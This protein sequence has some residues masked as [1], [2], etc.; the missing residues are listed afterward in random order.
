[1]IKPFYLDLTEQE[2]DKIKSK[3]GEILKSGNLILS[4]YTEDF[5]HEFAKYIGCKYAV[6]LNSCTSA[7]EA[8]LMVKDAKNKKVAV[9]TNTN[10]ATVAAIIRA[11]G[12]PIYMDMTPEYFV[13]DMNILKYTLKKHSDISGVVWVH[14][15]GIIAPDFEEIAEFCKSKNIFL[16]EDCAHAHGSKM[17]DIY[18]GNFGDAGAFSFFPTKVMTTM[19]GGMVTTNSS[20]DAKL[21]KSIRN[22]G[23]RTSNYGGLHIDLGNSWRMSEIQAY[24]G[25]TQL[26]KLDQMIEQRTKIVDALIPALKSKNIDYCDVNHMQKVSLY[27]F[28]I[29]FKNDCT[30]EHLKQQFKKDDV[31]LGGGVYDVPCH[32]QPV[33]KDIYFD[34]EDVK[35]A[36]EYCLKH[37]CLPITSGITQ[38][39]INILIATVKKYIQ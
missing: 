6:S 27:K 34:F 14:I 9:P 26:T 3:F 15:G 23:K 35:I 29:K 36:E 7:L 12:I 32:K 1:M 10:F 24:M 31:I 37:I 17:N 28:I 16:I 18:A 30:I 8:L 13:P 21:I 5:E 20:E 2:I 39:D 38:K 11:G 4:K 22:Q 25:I 33:F 19:E